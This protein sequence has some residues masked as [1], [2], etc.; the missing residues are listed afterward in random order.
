LIRGLSAHIA[1]QSLIARSNR[2]LSH[3]LRDVPGLTVIPVGGRIEAIRATAGAELIHA[4]ETGGAQVGFVRSLASGTPYL[5]TRRVDNKPSASPVTHWMYRRAARVVVL[6]NAIATTLRQYEPNIVLSKIPSASSNLEHDPQWVERYRAAGPNRFLVGH[7]AALDTRHKG[8]HTLI[9]AAK[10]IER[11]HPRIHFLIVGSG[12][13]EAE[14]RA[15]A[16]GSSNVSFM[17]WVRNVGDYL[18]ALD[19]FVY[20]SMH[21]GLG[22]ILLDAMQFGLPIVA[23]DVGGIPD[24]VKHAE[25]GLLVA[26]GDHE[27]LAAAI[28]RLFSDA[29]LRNAMAESNRR[30]AREYHPSIMT[31]RYLEIYRNLV[32]RIAA[33]RPS[34]P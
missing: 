33:D 29:P 6:S 34:A 11:T 30:R 16:A 20:P 8:Q 22:S 12:R 1:T 18:A 24:I 19:I 28:L 17:G 10:R 9:E 4:H 14:L 5:I 26:A 25:N 13:D 2:P 32:P 21:E 3:R 7:I 31:Q 27:A 23:S 15:Q